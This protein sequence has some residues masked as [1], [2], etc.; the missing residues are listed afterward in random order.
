MAA[1]PRQRVLTVRRA[2]PSALGRPHHRARAATLA[3]SH[4][5][6]E[7]DISPR[8]QGTLLLRPTNASLQT[9]LAGVLSSASSAQE[10]AIQFMAAQFRA[11]ALWLAKA[12]PPIYE[13]WGWSLKKPPMAA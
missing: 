6:N 3:Q 9:R 12:G 5:L 11:E 7:A 1:G 4:G 8:E 2:A 13:V 10:E